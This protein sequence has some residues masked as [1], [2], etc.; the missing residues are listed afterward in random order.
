VT[1]SLNNSTKKQNI[2]VEI[3]YNNFT[4][5]TIAVGYYNRKT[6]SGKLLEAPKLD[7]SESLGQTD[8]QITKNG[9]ELV[10]DFIE[11]DRLA[12]NTENLLVYSAILTK[13]N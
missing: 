12:N 9:K 7:L 6:Y 11:V 8:F 1:F 13:L 2:V 10:I 4:E 5:S 3:S